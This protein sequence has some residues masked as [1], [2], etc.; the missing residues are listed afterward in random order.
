MAFDDMGT[1]RMVHTPQSLLLTVPFGA[2]FTVGQMPKP[3]PSKLYG[4][5]G[6][7]W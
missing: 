5:P 3:V 1:S 6:V 4:A 7:Y 2:R